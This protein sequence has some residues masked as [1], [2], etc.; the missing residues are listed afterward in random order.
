MN[1][2]QLGIHRKSNLL[3][4]EDGKLDYM[5]QECYVKN[6]DCCH[7]PDHHCDKQ[8]KVEFGS[9]KD[10]WQTL[11]VFRHDC[12]K[13]NKSGKQDCL[14]K[15]DTRVIS[16]DYKDC[17]CQFVWKG[18]S[19]NV[20]KNCAGKW[21]TWVGGFFGLFVGQPHIGAA[22]GCGNVFGC[23]DVDCTFDDKF[24]DEEMLRCSDDTTNKEC[25][26]NAI[27]PRSK[28]E[29]PFGKKCAGGDKV[30][31]SNCYYEKAVACNGKNS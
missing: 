5:C 23:K 1:I 4:V 13:E 29:N 19:A 22:I 15:C 18:E 17:N 10:Q 27:T 31:C 30:L 12:N 28:V 11:K 2:L 8:Y 7:D 9:R 26:V 25:N 20:I 3:R 21:E 14:P 16:T 6:V 24:Y